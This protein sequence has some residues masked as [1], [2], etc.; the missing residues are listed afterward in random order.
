MDS[1]P[2]VFLIIL[3]T[4]M[5]CRP[6]F[7][8][9]CGLAMLFAAL[10][11]A[12]EPIDFDRQIRP[13][14]ANTCFTCHGPDEARREAELRLDREEDAKASVIVPGDLEQSEL[15]RRITSED[16]FERMP[17][18]DAKQ[19]LS[20]AQV[21]LLKKWV[22]A[23]APWTQHWSF[24]PPQAA[25]LPAVSDPHWPRNDI[26]YFILNRLD[27]EK[28]K[29]SP[30]ADKETL[31]RRVTLDLTG[32]PPTLEE[33]DAFLSDD[34]PAAYE[35]VV[36]RL[37]A[38]PRYGEHMA[39][40]WLAAARYS[41]TN[42]YQDDAT[43]T[44]WPWRDWVIR[45][46]N[47]NLPF[48]KFTLY[49][50]AGDLLPNPTQEQLIATGFNR[51]N[52]LNGEGGRNPEESR[53]EYVVDRVDTTST[54][55]LGLTV[56]CARCHD[57]K[58]D[59]I[60][61]KEFYRLYAYF[62]N[63]EENG[64]IDL[65]PLAKPVLPLPTDEQT[66]NVAELREKI[67]GVEKQIAD[68]PDP[69]AEEA[70]EWEAFAQKWL[71]AERNDVLWEPLKNPELKTKQGSKL[72]LLDDDSVLLTEIADSNEDYT[73][74]VPL[75]AGTHYGLRLEAM[76][77]ES[78]FN[79]LFST[80]ISGDYRVTTIEVELDGEKVKLIEPQTDV[81]GDDP[82]A[83]L[84]GNIRTGFM[85]GKPKDAK[86]T[87]IWMARFEKPI[88]AKAQSESKTQSNSKTQA[89]LVV[90]LRNESVDSYAPIGR[91][92]VSLTQYPRPTIAN[93]LGFTDETVASLD[94]PATERTPDQLKLISKGTR[95]NLELP[96]RDEIRVAEQT[97]ATEEA[98]FLKTMI[99][100]DRA[101]PRETYRLERGVWD[102]ADKSEQLF[103]NVPECLPPL[104]ADAPANRLAL[105]KW[106]ID[107]SHPLTA[108]V[109]VNRYWQHFFGV[110]LVK[111]S[112]DFGVQGERP[113]HQELL[114]WLAVEFVRSGWD[115]KA[116][117]KLIVTSAT[118]QQS[119]KVSPELAER[120]IYNRLLARGPRFR[121]SSLALRDQ[122]LALSGLLV[123]KMGGPGVMPYQPDGVW[124]DFS[125]GKISYKRSEGDDLYRRS[126]YT[127]WRRSVG[128]TLYFDSP[129]RQVC[130]VRPSLT[131]T[132]L[133][134][135][136]LLNDTTFIEAARVFA[137]RILHEA[138]PDPAE[139]I[140]L[141]FRLASS[142]EPGDE[143]LARLLETLR[144]L[145][146]EYRANPDSAKE[147]IEVGE[148]PHDETLDIIETAAYGSLMNVILNLDEVENKS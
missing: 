93:N 76:K 136:T 21:E 119:S 128:P 62:N 8:L 87:R 35:K 26:D 12:E 141:A 16:E 27:R 31:L 24:T 140:S 13:I 10:V 17:P 2:F 100:R 133:H 127:F 106:L 77:H 107:S 71:A 69:T 52:T 61:H 72:K 138:S 34:S 59:P 30:M 108:R 113:L 9:A 148:A 6:I 32:L 51:N 125:L 73:L 15:I 105:A 130:T 43:R 70:T 84:D 63:V 124:E 94:A 145:L 83:P 137:E 65:F 50:L 85:A 18:T 68:I 91:F 46:L 49:Q 146:D 33:L 14:L 36:D 41:D 92:R 42:G 81:A 58:Y 97:I 60:T 28:L 40:E 25:P 38:S 142:R 110:G 95:A 118:Y 117:H 20:P 120:D 102:A 75:P 111:T 126:I 5:P 88:S 23:G 57:H 80:S 47:D 103:P 101:E 64:G 147:F 114:D 37:L 86:K 82:K 1:I 96:L 143:E 56:A 44:N 135:L 134:A 89:K 131:N 45:A 4:S 29:P 123:K 121:L 99:M 39:L 109:T 98:G 11:C 7:Y 132:P 116:M 79:G 78:L 112:E 122:A 90:R 67:A 22:A 66:K 53:V 19:Q 55:W 54:V 104:P 139:R 144:F 48:D 74:T 115:A 129:G 3:N